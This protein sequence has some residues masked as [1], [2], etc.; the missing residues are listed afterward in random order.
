MSLHRFFLD[1]QILSE[2]EGD[3]FQLGLNSEDLKHA[4][5][6]RLQ[7]GEH[8]AVIDAAS[9]YFECSVESLGRNSC[10]VRIA[11]RLDAP[12]KPYS[13]TLFQ[14]L[15]KGERFESVLRHASE[16]GIDGIVPYASERSV[17][18][19]DAKRAEQK[20]IRWS[21]IAKSAAKQAGLIRIPEVHG[22]VDTDGACA[23]LAEFDAVLICW[24][25]CEVSL[26]MRAFFQDI[27]A[28]PGL[29][30]AVVVGPEGGLSE[31][32]VS[33]LLECNPNA[34]LVSLGSTIL[35]TETA[36]IAS[37]AIAVSELDWKFMRTGAQGA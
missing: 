28:V 1:S 19:L 32:E 8:I 15:A 31:E 16:F 22:V 27:Q 10:E 2:V 30:A 37:V 4:N 5:V 33:R 9:D 17:V 35:R 7:A 36:G 26:S 23:S 14:G 12:S 24:E 21:S 11:R 20:L 13:L 3:I 25:E 18:K 6:L 34:A 29:D